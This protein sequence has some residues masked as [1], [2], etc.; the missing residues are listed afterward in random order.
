MND[1]IGK[2]LSEKS[3]NDTRAVIDRIDTELLRLLNERA[4]VALRVGEAKSAADAALC[5]PARERQVL[6][7]VSAENPG[8]FDDSSI[9]NIFQRII[10]E[11]LYLQQ[12]AY[13]KPLDRTSMPSSA[14]LMAKRSRVAFLGERGTFSHEAV[15]AILGEECEPVSFPTFD[16][17]FGAIERGDSDYILTPLENTLVGSVHRCYDLLLK[18]DLSIAAEVILPVA[19]FLV[20]CPEAAFETIEI[21]ESHPAALAQ[22]ERFFAAYPHIK[23]VAGND[24]AGSVKRAVESGDP[25]RAGI[26]SRRTAELYGGKI[27]REHIQDH[28]E[29]F[30]RFVLLSRELQES[31]SGDKISMVL[32]LSHEP[33][34][35]HNA[36]RAFV[37]RGIDLLKIESRPIKDSPAQYHFYLDIRPPASES[38]LRGALD[39]INEQAS[40]VRYLG[41]Y[42]TVHL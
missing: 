30:T 14:D 41:R 35:L 8:P 21:V 38:E 1:D 23:R 39:E 36:L 32:T 2:D 20:A 31:A 11:S 6:S 25:T 26:G 9:E 24:T 42:P 10:D 15:L 29:N 13:H 12:R 3:F 27:L 17:L 40:E 33:G 34:S 5:D 7:R 19:H 18:S 28:S 4:A 22:C 16:D 37:R